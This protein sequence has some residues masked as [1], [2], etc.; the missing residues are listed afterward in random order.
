MDLQEGHP[1]Y[2]KGSFEVNRCSTESHNDEDDDAD[3]NLQESLDGS[4]QYNSE[5][6]KV[7]HRT[8]SDDGLKEIEDL[9]RNETNVLRIF[10]LLMLVLIVGT[11]ALVTTG[12]YIFLRNV[13]ESTTNQSVSVLSP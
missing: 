5:S 13:Q 7:T 3:S 2:D 8:A 12:T 1:N 9:A 11:C 4:S 6:S 10:R